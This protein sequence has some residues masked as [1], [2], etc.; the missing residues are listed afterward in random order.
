MALST[1][2]AGGLSLETAITISDNKYLEYQVDS[3]HYNSALAGHF[4]DFSGHKVVG[5]PDVFGSAS[6]GYAPAALKGIAFR[7][8]MQGVGKY[9]ADDANVVTVP[10]YGLVDASISLDRPLLLGR[11][12]G[13]RGFV[14]VNNAGDRRYMGSAFLNPDVVNGVPVAFEPGLPRNVVV[15][16]SLARER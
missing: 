14:G 8:G 6:L 1:R 5:L 10:G 3:V 9:F 13:L 12:I 7:V 16:F 4:A 15:S 11:E 2:S